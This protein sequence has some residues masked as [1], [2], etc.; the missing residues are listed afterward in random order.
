MKKADLYRMF[1]SRVQ[2]FAMRKLDGLRFT[3]AVPIAMSDLP[4]QQQKP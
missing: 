3:M 4:L 1:A 2:L